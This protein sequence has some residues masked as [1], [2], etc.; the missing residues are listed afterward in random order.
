MQPCDIIVNR[1]LNGILIDVSNKVYEN[2]LIK[3]NLSNYSQ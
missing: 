2:K 3:N 1:I